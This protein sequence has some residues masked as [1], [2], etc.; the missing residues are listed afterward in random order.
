MQPHI[1]IAAV[2]VGQHHIHIHTQH[3][4]KLDLQ[5]KQQSQWDRSSSGPLRGQATHRTFRCYRLAARLTKNCYP[6]TTQWKNG[7]YKLQ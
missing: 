3:L 1:H 2:P 6:V 5:R 7:G 4:R